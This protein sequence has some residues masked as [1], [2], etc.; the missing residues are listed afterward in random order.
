MRLGEGVGGCCCS[1]KHKM[2]KCDYCFL[3]PKVGNKK[4]LFTKKTLVVKNK[5][6]SG[7]RIKETHSES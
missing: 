1:A 7:C 4:I 5:I 2:Y 3:L 6:F